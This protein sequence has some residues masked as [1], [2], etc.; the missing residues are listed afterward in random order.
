M[1]I[2]RRSILKGLAATPLFLSGLSAEAAGDNGT[3]VVVVGLN[4]GNDGLNTVIPLKQYAQYNKLRS[5]P[6]SGGSIAYLQPQLQVT[7]F[8]PNPATPAGSATQFAFSPDMPEMRQLYG[9]G[10]LAV[11]MGIGLPNAELAPLSHFNAW[12][13]WSTGQ[14]NVSSGALPPGW[15][16]A[17]FATGGSGALGPTASMNGGQLVAT[18]KGSQGLVVGR[19]EDFNLTSPYYVPQFELGSAYQRMLGIKP[20]NASATV[21]RNVTSATLNAVGAMQGY[22]Q[23]AQDY[24][25][26]NSELASQLRV[27]AQMIIGGSGVRGYV[28]VEYGFDTHSGQN[29][30]HP[31]LLQDVSQS[32]TQFY[33]YLKQ[34]KVSKN[35]LIVTISDFGRTP[36]ANLSLGTDHGAAS[37]AF[38]IGDMVKGGAYG[39]YPSLTNFDDNGNLLVHVDFRNLLSDVIQAAGGNPTPILGTTYPKLGFI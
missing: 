16:G 13:D 32:L 21:A 39:T 4:G 31:Q 12:S 18:T 27:I 2:K 7:A 15:L 20:T 14:I 24:P 35:V 38:V 11:I 26:S 23:L 1:L 28:A 37:V 29:N 36:G 33:A 3:I 34:K 25:D 8:D 6:G 10:K 9:T 5:P 19:P 17:A 30:D 22:A